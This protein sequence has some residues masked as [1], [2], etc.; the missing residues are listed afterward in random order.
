MIW[1]IKTL[2][3]NSYARD[4]MNFSAKLDSELE[5]LFNRNTKF[6][7]I[8]IDYKTSPLIL[9]LEEVPETTNYSLVFNKELV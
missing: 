1:K 5:I 2:D 6:R 4:I 9:E 3:E 8:K 7:I